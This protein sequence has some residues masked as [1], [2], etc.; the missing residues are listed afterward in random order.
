MRVPGTVSYPSGKKRAQAYIDE[1][2][3]LNI[4]PSPRPFTDISVWSNVLPKTAPNE[5]LDIDLGK[6]SLDLSALKQAILSGQNWHDNML[7]LVGRLVADGLPKE[8][9]LDRA[10]EFTLAG[11][12]E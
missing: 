9:I 11:Y 5:T 10:A 4:N 8:E 6:N 1:L 2:V 7:R 12:T 3:V